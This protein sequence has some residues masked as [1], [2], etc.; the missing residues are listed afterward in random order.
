[1]TSM[2]NVAFISKKQFSLLGIR[3]FVSKYSREVQLFFF[4]SL[5]RISENNK[6]SITSVA[7]PA[8]HLNL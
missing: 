3:T 1:M 7:Q 8:G 4:F 6:S 2:K 5:S